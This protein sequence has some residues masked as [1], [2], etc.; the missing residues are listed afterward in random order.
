[1]GAIVSGTVPPYSIVVG[2]RGEVKKQRDIDVYNRL[3]KEGKIYM[4]YKKA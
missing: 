3:K 2:P 4:K 1:M